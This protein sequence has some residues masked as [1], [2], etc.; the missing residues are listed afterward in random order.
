MTVGYSAV[1]F[2]WMTVLAAQSNVR[3]SVSHLG[4]QDRLE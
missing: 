3:H 4:H 2:A 1:I